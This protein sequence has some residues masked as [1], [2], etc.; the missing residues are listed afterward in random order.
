MEGRRES[1]QLTEI[2]L[3]SDRRVNSQQLAGRD[4]GEETRALPQA[5]HVQR[6]QACHFTPH[7][8]T[9]ALVW[10]KALPRL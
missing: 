7:Q 1:R 5:R 10:H 8:L 6:R 3:K 9:R 2:Q 4:S